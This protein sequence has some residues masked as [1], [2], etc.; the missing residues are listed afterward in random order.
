MPDG[1]LARMSKR[2]I[3][4]IVR[5]SIEHVAAT[6]AELHVFHVST[7]SRPEG[8]THQNGWSADATCVVPMRSKKFGLVL[9]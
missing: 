2:R 9:K 6:G 5:Q 7:R 8:P 4:E 1:V 3:A